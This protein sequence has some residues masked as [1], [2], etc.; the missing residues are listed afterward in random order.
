MFC[1]NAGT[2][3]C[4]CHVLSAHQVRSHP[5]CEAHHIADSHCHPAPPSTVP[6]T[7]I[8]I[9]AAVWLALAP[10]CNLRC[11]GA[12]A[13]R[14]TGCVLAPSE[15]MQALTSLVYLVWALALY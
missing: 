14:A 7:P 10:C 5:R 3:G 13:Y 6:H 4:S 9:N 11:L 8:L 15:Y 12:P 2:S 1:V